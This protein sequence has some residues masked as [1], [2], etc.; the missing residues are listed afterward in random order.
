[1]SNSK[2][3]EQNFS[4]VTNQVNKMR[5]YEE[6]I[7]D[8]KV[9]DKILR[10]I[11]IKFDHVITTIFESRNTNVMILEFQSIKSHVSKILEKIEKVNLN[12][13]VESNP[14]VESRD[15]DNFNN[16]ERR[17][18]KGRGRR[19]TEE[20]D[21]VI[22]TKEETTTSYIQSRKRWKK[23]KFYQSRKRTR[24]KTT[25]KEQILIVFNAKSSNTK[26]HID[27]GCSKHMCGKNKLFSTLDETVKFTIKF[28]NNTNIHIL[29]KYQIIIKLKDD[30]Q[31]FI[32]YVFYISGFHHNLLSMR[33]IL[34]KD[35]IIHIHHEN[36][37]FGLSIINI[38]SEVCEIGKK[39]KESFP[40]RK[41]W[42]AKK[43][44]EIVHS[45]LCTV[46]I[47]THGGR[48]Y[49]ITFI[50]DFSRKI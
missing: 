21:L 18:Y 38:P 8:N 36:N 25:M 17:N 1:M 31:N 7:L 22:S 5:V 26:L 15:H 19:I 48:K 39:H 11:S 33:Q 13:D 32:Y 20:E 29:E 30:S 45:D 47:S 6:Q 50:D 9:V 16:R 41:S 4:H 12:N 40:T 10:I 14:S 2:S 37:V 43:P 44:L 27:I 23:F 24:K 35:Y 42:K 34:E 28:E 3:I 46:E 49:F